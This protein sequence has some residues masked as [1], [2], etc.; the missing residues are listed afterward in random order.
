MKST[1]E[2]LIESLKSIVYAKP[3]ELQNKIELAK[4]LVESKDLTIEGVS[5]KELH[6]QIKLLIEK[7]ENFNKLGDYWAK[8]IYTF[9]HFKFDVKTLSELLEKIE[10]K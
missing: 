2:I 6:D 3:E 1:E 7:P 5:T 10:A 9:E 4:E 8:N